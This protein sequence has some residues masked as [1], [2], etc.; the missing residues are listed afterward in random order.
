VL[1]LVLAAV[2]VIIGL[3]IRSAGGPEGGDGPPFLDRVSGN[4]LFLAFTGLATVVPFFLPLATGVVAG[5]AV[6]G[7]AQAGTL[8]YLLT[9]PVS[10]TRLLLVKYGGLVAFGLAASLVVAAV[11]L[12]VGAVLFPIGDVTLLSGTTVSLA[13]GIGRALLVALY[14][15]ASLAG[16]AA[17]GLAVSTFTEVPVAAM[18]TTV[19]LAIT[20]Q[21]LARSRSSTGCTR[22]CSPTTGWPS[23]TWSAAR[24]RPATCSPGCCC[25]PGGSSSRC[26]SPGAGS[27]PATSPAERRAGAQE[28]TLRLGVA[29]DP[30]CGTIDRMT[31]PAV[32]TDAATL[33]SGAAMPLLGFGTWQLKG[34]TAVEAT[35]AA[36]DAG[37]RHLDTATIYGNEREVGRALAGRDDVFVTTKLPPDRGDE[38]RETLEQSLEALGLDQVSLWLVHWPPDSGA[39]VEVWEA[40]VQAQ[41]DGLARDIGV[42]NYSF[43]QLDALTKATG[44]Q[45]A[46]NQVKWSPL[47]HDA[48]ARRGPPHPRRGARGL[49]RAQGRHPRPP[50]DHGHR[51]AARPH[52]GAGRRPLAPRARLRRHPEVLEPRADR[53]ERRRR[54]LRAVARRHRDAR[55]AGPL[56]AGRAR[57]RCPRGGDRPPADRG[58]RGLPARRAPQPLALASPP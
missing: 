26:R 42:S 31:H 30:G 37:Y 20:S 23:A 33:P 57:R 29:P 50:G 54:R 41:A 9:V 14:V 49:Q 47:L 34:S 55:R 7:E 10:R 45:P 32:P 16:L 52:P 8:R 28:H 15:A 51:R 12:L 46:V 21:I 5:D 18:A 24:S 44:V 11:G 35:T 40:F 25:R 27:P 19:V 22:C 53:G 13:S 48:Q 38:A 1:L 56:S 17:I 6:A 36:L 3:A 4:G 2:P 58:L 43:D 39:G